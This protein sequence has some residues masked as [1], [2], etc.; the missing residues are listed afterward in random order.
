MLEAL[1]FL[2]WHRDAMVSDFS[3]IISSRD[4][5]SVKKSLI[6]DESRL[7][8]FGISPAV[9]VVDMCKSCMIDRYPN[10]MNQEAVRCAGNIRKL[11][12][13]CRTL[14]IPVL[15]TTTLS[16]L[17]SKNDAIRGRW[18]EK[19][20]TIGSR[21]ARHGKD[22][23]F[24]IAPEKD[25]VVLEK[26][27]ASAFFGTQLSSILNFLRIDTL[28]VTGG[29]T[30]GCVRATVC[31][32]FQLNYK[33]IIPLECVWDFSEISHWVNLFDVSVRY[34]DVLMLSTVIHHL[35]NDGQEGNLLS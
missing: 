9:I 21:D 4:L 17:F 33:V 2:S 16:I 24:R 22:I 13:C 11:I 5:R 1:I 6:G 14:H 29:S 19:V 28:L 8:G 32:A 18:K 7:M 12:S 34:A 10:R 27:K 23:Y 26:D 35:K 20:T 3:R 25:D 30:S 31:D 15:Y